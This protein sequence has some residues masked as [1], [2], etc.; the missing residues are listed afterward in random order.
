MLNLIVILLAVISTGVFWLY[1]K[2][3]SKKDERLKSEFVTVVTHKFRTPITRIKWIIDMLHDNTTFQKK[4]DLLKDMETA[5]QQITEIIDLLTDF[6]SIAAKP[7]GEYEPIALRELITD[8]I[9]KHGQ[10]TREKQITFDLKVNNDVPSLLIEKNK[11]QF[12]IDAMI[13][14]AIKYTPT[15]GQ[16]IVG[17]ERHGKTILLSVKDNGIGIN[18]KDLD[19]IFRG[20][21]RGAEATTI[22]TTGMGLSL[23]TAQAIVENQGGRMWAESSGPGLG[24]TFYVQLE[25]KG[26]DFKFK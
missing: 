4:E 8:S 11:I 17:L 16:I 7:A 19:L 22:D 10:Q 13:E 9:N 26:Y 14:N 12:V 3:Q 6:T 25:I 21:W 23:H 24:A 5:V 15:Q 2:Q 20:F 18:P 1:F